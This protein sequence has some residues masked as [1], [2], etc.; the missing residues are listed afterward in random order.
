MEITEQV[1]HL[2]AKVATE[3]QARFT[4]FSDLAHGFS[5]P[6]SRSATRSCMLSRLYHY[7]RLCAFRFRQQ[8]SECLR[9]QKAGH[10]PDNYHRQQ[11]N[12]SPH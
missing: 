8:G 2:L 1:I 10:S 6:G 5:E 9:Y 3:V 4:D 7:L 12:L 11:V